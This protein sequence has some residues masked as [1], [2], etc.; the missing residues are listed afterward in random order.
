[1]MS[2]WWR[3]SI[4]CNLVCN[5]YKVPVSEAVACVLLVLRKSLNTGKIPKSSDWNMCDV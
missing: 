2:G 5:D 1:M 3:Y 4:A